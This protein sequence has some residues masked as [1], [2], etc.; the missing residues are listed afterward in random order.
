MV[1]HRRVHS[2]EN[3]KAQVNR[4][5][6]EFNR[7]IITATSLNGAAPPGEPYEQLCF[8]RQQNIN[9]WSTV[10]Q[11]A[12]SVAGHLVNNCLFLIPRDNTLGLYS[13]CLIEC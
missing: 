9:Y 6:I 8:I 7:A 5:A 13:A 10:V 4:A 11:E 1:D 3:L 12:E 2:V